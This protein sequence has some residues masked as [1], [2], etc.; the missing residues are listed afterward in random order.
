MTWTSLVI[1][2]GVLAVIFVFAGL[3][4]LGG[5]TRG[6]KRLVERFP[7][8]LPALDAA[9]SGA[10]IAVS[11]AGV[12]GAGRVQ[13]L[14]VT[15]KLDATYLHLT[16]DLGLFGPKA[17]ASIPWDEMTV[18]SS[19]Q[20]TDLGKMAVIEVG[21]ITV[22]LPVHLIEGRTGAGNTDE[23]EEGGVELRP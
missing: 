6:M 8:C 12:A 15:V 14:H 16:P 3:S 11:E 17:G 2:G 5:H 22:W 20:A 10:L 19:T 23:P 7:A 4:Q 13:F 9:N 1:L 18:T 21:E